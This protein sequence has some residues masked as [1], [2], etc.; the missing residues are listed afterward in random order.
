[1]AIDDCKQS[2]G[3]VNLIRIPLAALCAATRLRIPESG[4]Q[5]NLPR[6]ATAVCIRGRDY[7]PSGVR[8]PNQASRTCW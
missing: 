8:T 3:D 7:L 2:P 5:T 6:R 4:D 1:M